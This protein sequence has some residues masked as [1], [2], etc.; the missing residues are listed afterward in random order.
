MA[1]AEKA[2]TYRNP[3][4]ESCADP[5]VKRFGELYY[6]YCTYNKPAQGEGIRLYTSPDLVDWTDRGFALNSIDSWGER[7]FWAPD[8]IEKDGVYYLYYGVET[9]TCVA[10]A[11]SPLGPFKQTTAQPMEPQ[12]SIRIDAHVFR[13]DD[14][15]MW[16]YFVKFDRGNEIWVAR[17]NE[18]MTSVDVSTMTRALVA[19]QPWELHGGRIV[20]GPEMIKHKGHYYLTYS[21]S[22]YR[23][24][25]Y[26]VGYAVSGTPTG[27]FRKYEGNPV[28]KQTDKVC[29]PGHH[30]FAKSPDG[31]ET[32]IVYHVHF[33]TKK[34]LPRKLAIDR[35]R[36]VPQADGPDILEVLGP[37]STPQPAPSQRSKNRV[38]SRGAA[39][40]RAKRSVETAL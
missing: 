36:F 39:D 35:I 9:R 19:D 37:T 7:L 40:R 17:L 13:D 21:G 18:D 10:T 15:K 4:M 29:G 8:I 23:D 27:P 12:D 25:R 32:F 38:A 34:P 5:S 16:L 20:E 3:V 30:C 24:R 33:S 22:H 26:A 11:D 28:L 31:S 1:A 2:T 14:G 6:C